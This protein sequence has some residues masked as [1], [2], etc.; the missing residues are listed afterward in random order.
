MQ[1][2]GHKKKKCK[3]C[4]GH[5]CIHENPTNEIPKETEEKLAQKFSIAAQS[6]DILEQ[7]LIEK[8]GVPEEILKI[9]S[10]EELVRIRFLFQLQ[11]NTYMLCVLTTVFVSF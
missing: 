7:F 1:G 4:K 5:P 2:K 8:E 11:S 3:Q 9:A 6:M 10:K